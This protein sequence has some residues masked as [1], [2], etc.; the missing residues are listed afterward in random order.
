M[1]IISSP[2]AT[3][4]SLSLLKRNQSKEISL[5]REILKKKQK[6]Q[7]KILDSLRPF[8][9]KPLQKRSSL[10]KKRVGV[11]VSNRAQKTIVVAVERRFQ[12]PTYAKTLVQTKRYL[13]HDEKNTCKIGDMVLIQEGRPKSKKKHW[14]LKEII[15]S[16]KNLPF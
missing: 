12:H 15:T 8:L 3:S 9:G 2:S 6:R 4:E 7:K 5:S 16:Y 11:V 10:E 1:A 14:F 13:T